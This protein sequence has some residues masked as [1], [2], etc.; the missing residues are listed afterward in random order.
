MTKDELD[1]S[2]EPMDAIL[3]GLDKATIHDAINWSD[4]G[5]RPS[6]RSKAL[7]AMPLEHRMARLDRGSFA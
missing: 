2:R 7:P 6:R 1:Y 4:L 3:A 5:C